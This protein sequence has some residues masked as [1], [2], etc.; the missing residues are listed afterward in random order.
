MVD[1]NMLLRSPE[2]L[3]ILLEDVSLGAL[4]STDILN[5]FDK[6]E[7]LFLREGIFPLDGNIYDPISREN[8]R[9][10]WN[11]IR[12]LHEDLLGNLFSRE[13][14]FIFDG[15]YI[16]Y[17]SFQSSF[18]VFIWDK[19]RSSK[20]FHSWDVAFLKEIGET[21]VGFGQE[22]KEYLNRVLLDL[23]NKDA[24]FLKLVK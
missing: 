20:Y 2:N 17:N 12:S 15:K 1:N 8:Y 6:Y 5:T 22:G 10:K 11:N 19:V 4:L 9:V 7:E 16:I 24:R 14:Y 18:S 13:F 3:S 23:S 21:G